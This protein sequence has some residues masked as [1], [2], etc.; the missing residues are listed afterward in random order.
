MIH[1]PYNRALMNGPSLHEILHAWANF[2]VPTA[3]GA[4]WGFSSANGQ[5][6]GFDL[7]NLED[8]GGGRYAAGR[9]G[10]FAN[11]GNG[12]PYSPIELYF[13]GFLPPEG[14]PDL[15]V[16]ED[17]QWVRGADGT[18][19]RTEAGSGIFE[20]AD[21]RTYTV[22]DIVERNGPRAPAMGEAQWNFR[23]ALILLTDDDHPATQDQLDT[24]S[25]HAAWFSQPGSDDR[26]WLHNFHE[27]TQGRGSITLDGLAEVRRAT[28]GLPAG[29][30][31]SYGTV[32][33]PHAS[34]IDGTCVSVDTTRDGGTPVVLRTPVA[35]DG[36]VLG[37]SGRAPR[38]ASDATP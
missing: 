12:P 37:P 2:A 24:M 8:L 15:W 23:A 34:L 6:G 30:P 11:G 22:D 10:T 36:F 9:F 35:W 5:L 21:V 28:A 1:F 17:G 38:P 32:P 27:A 16:A 13:A 18:R 19:A 14:V 31:A 4:H 25:R 33:P 20:A 29:L 3:V 26:D 7:A